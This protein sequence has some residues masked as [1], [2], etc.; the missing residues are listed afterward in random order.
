[1]LVHPE[2]YLKGIADLCRAH[3]VLL[4]AD[5]IATGFGRTG[6]MF[7]CEKEDVAPDILCLGKGITGGYL[8]VAVTLATSDIFDAFLGDDTE[9]RTFFHGHTYTGN[10]LGCA[11]ALAAIERFGKPERARVPA[12]Q[13]RS[14][15]APTRPFRAPRPRGRRAAV[16]LYCRDRT[17]CR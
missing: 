4:I 16:R 1:M 5:E 6:A 7:A 8:P 17:G 15:R 10:P 3:D 9:G 13:D 14:P 12:A 11:A 2:G